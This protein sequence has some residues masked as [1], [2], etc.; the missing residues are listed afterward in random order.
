MDIL[1]TIAYD[2]TNYAGW[3]RQDNA[4]TIQQRVEEAVGAVLTGSL[5]SSLAGS[6]TG[7]LT[8]SLTSSLTGSARPDGSVLI[9][10]AS[11]T[12]A[13]VHS[14]SQQ[15][16][17]SATHMP[18]P[19]E[20][21]PQV[22]NSHLP[23]DIA[24]QNAVVVPDGFNPRFSA[25]AKT[26]C[27]QIYN[28]THP[29]PLFSRY[30]AFVPGRL[31]VPNMAHAAKYFVGTF[32]FAAFCASG[33]GAK[34]TTRTVF[35]CEVKNDGPLIKMTVIGNG[36]LY[37]MVRIMAGTVLYVGMGKFSPEE[38]P[39]IIEAKDRALAGKTMPPEGLVL[40]DVDFFGAGFDED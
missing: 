32:D 35:G 33:S 30:S 18:I 8:D 39:R 9:L 25:K 6:L 40:M 37:N 5:T 15:A 4:M 12:D 27:Y 34:T 14:M 23:R 22:I 10:G 24:V 38:V 28:G 17:F 13:G 2:G 7:S 26:Y 21:L 16:V 31:N 29:N 3:Q 36:F 19:L 20:K 1:L 11:R